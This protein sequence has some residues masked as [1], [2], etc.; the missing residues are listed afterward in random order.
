MQSTLKC[1]CYLYQ[2]KKGEEFARD[3][4]FPPLN[5]VWSFTHPTV[6]KHLP[7]GP[8]ELGKNCDF[9]HIINRGERLL[10]FG[11]ES[12][13]N[14]V[15]YDGDW[16]WPTHRGPGVYRGTLAITADNAKT[17]YLDFEVSYNNWIDDEATMFTEGLTLK[18]WHR[19]RRRKDSRVAVQAL[20]VSS[21]Q[22]DVQ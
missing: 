10:E 16:V 17:A 9:F 6:M 5:L 13:P 20:N 8:P 3:V 19:S 22:Q 1:G 7:A 11:T 18:S 21:I 15:D 12:T 4:H 2:Q 14:K